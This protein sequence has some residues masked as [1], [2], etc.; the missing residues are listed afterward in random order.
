VTVH[1][2]PRPGDEPG[3]ALDAFT[4]LATMSLADASPDSALEKVVRAALRSVPGA[5]DVSVTVLRDGR[6]ETAA[7]TGA[8]AYDAD[9][10][11]YALSEGPCLDA[12]AGGEVQHVED[13]RT[14]TRWP[15]YAPAGTER[16]VG[17]S[18]SVPL[19][20][21]GSVTG[22]LNV[23]ADRPAA[24]DDA[25]C[26]LAEA[27]ACYAA[28][29]LFNVRTYR[30]AVEEAAAIRRAMES[31]AVIEQAKGVLMCQ[32]TC[33]AEEAFEALVRLSQQHNIKLRTVA[34]EVVA[35][36]LS[37]RAQG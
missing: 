1:T 33:T 12:G 3:L 29:A 31:R 24:F 21:Q 14:E 11:Q 5:A 17:S 13:L 25:A 4:D 9:Q 20:E 8:L 34:A 18:L 15:A 36:V 32:R 6:A 22:A 37:G 35:A 10:I 27:L 7:H 28:V 19:P 30:S 26:R 2:A 23:Y 16:G